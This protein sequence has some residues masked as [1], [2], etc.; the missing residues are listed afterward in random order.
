MQ[1]GVIVFKWLYIIASGS[2]LNYMLQTL[3]CLSRMFKQTAA[4]AFR[5]KSNYHYICI[6][7]KDILH[8]YDFK[9]L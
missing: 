1:T 2:I 7:N 8:Y 4:Y 9:S 3:L 6:A 5:L